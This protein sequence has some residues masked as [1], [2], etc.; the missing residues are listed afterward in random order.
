MHLK[1]L[2]CLP[3][4][5]LTWS[6]VKGSLFTLEIAVDFSPQLRKHLTSI[7]F[8][9][10][11]VFCLETV[12]PGAHWLFHGIYFIDSE[13]LG[14]C[15]EWALCWLFISWEKDSSVLRN[16]NDGKGKDYLE[17]N[18]I[19][20]TNPKLGKPSDWRKTLYE[21]TF[22]HVCLLSN[23]VDGWRAN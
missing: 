15:C 21:I 23:F 1:C 9:C 3:V 10:L 12:P 17:S 22:I 18:F 7:I 11:T 19:D 5:E 13:I 4:G 14:V 20:L 16:V 2:H 6:S 8:L